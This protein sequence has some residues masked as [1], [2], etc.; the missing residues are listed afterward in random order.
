M[1]SAV[2]ECSCGLILRG[3]CLAMQLKGICEYHK[4][5]LPYHGL[6]WACSGSTGFEW[7]L[8]GESSLLRIVLWSLF[9]EYDLHASTEA[10][11]LIRLVLCDSPEAIRHECPT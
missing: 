4:G 1:L 3:Q 6:I 7:L 9:L 11:V 5:C 8:E 2:A 10:M